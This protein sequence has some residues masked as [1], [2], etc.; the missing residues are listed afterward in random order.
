MSEDPTPTTT[1]ATAT[2]PEPQEPVTGDLTQEVEKWKAMSRKNE[3]KAK[4]NAAAAKELEALKLSQMSDLDKAVVEATAKGRAEAMQQVSE[5]LVAA[6]VKAAASGRIE[7]DALALLIEGMNLSAFVTDEGEV[8]AAKVAKYVD[9]IAPAKT[10]SPTAP[11]WP[12]LGQGAKGQG[13]AAGADPL[14][15]AVTGK[16]GITQ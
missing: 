1:A 15:A 10:E 6:E 12:D 14:L 4:A 3:E 16:L 13:S 9:G 2:D 11:A 8:D 5:K 7:A